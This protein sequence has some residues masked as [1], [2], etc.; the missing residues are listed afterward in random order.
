MGQSDQKARSQSSVIKETEKLEKSRRPKTD[1]TRNFKGRQKWRVLNKLLERV[2]EVK[3]LVSN[4][5]PKPLGNLPHRP[6]EG[7]SLIVIAL[8]PWPSARSVVIK[9]PL[10]SSSVNCPS[11]DSLEKLLRISKLILG[12]KVLLLV[13]FKRPLRLTSLVFLK[14]PTCA[15]FT[16]SV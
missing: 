10:N 3:L 7:R 15:P 16:Q 9:S 4:W 5:P 13:P 2:L 12:F 8:E 11:S 14:I 1:K 6:E